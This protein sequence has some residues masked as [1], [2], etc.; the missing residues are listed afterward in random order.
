GVLEGRPSRRIELQL[1]EG[2]PRVAADVVR[3]CRVGPV[4][5]VGVA[6]RRA[7]GVGELGC[8]LVI[9]EVHA[10]PEGDPVLEVERAARPVLPGQD[11]RVLRH[12]YP[13]LLV[14]ARTRRVGVEEQRG[15][16]M[17]RV[18]ALVAQGI[19]CLGAD[20]ASLATQELLGVS[21]L[22]YLRPRRGRR[23]GSGYRRRGENYGPRTY[24]N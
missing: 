20:R 2:R 5:D 12:D 8:R 18:L 23:R 13:V 1:Q 3:L 11:R 7:R 4:E 10:E 17:P 6:V 21:V 16:V 24:H 14:V 9:A 15:L 22:G 19:G